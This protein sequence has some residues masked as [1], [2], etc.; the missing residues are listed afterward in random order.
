MKLRRRSGM[1]DRKYDRTGAGR[2]LDSTSASTGDSLLDLT[3][4]FFRGS[5]PGRKCCRRH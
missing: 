2:L 5:L 1:R 4:A 3:G